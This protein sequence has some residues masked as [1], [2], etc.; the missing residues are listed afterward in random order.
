M[1]TEVGSLCAKLTGRDAGKECLIVK[2]LDNAMVLIDGNT[3]RRKCNVHH[4]EFLGK[5]AK[6]KEN[7]S[8]EEVMS[9]LKG[10]GIKPIKRVG[11]KPKKEKKE[12]KPKKKL[13]GKKEAKI[14]PK[15]E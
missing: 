1:V 7:A 14:K 13:F 6:I 9:A 4:L 12:E 8:H 5:K 2:K 3:R 15:K 11:P 10:F